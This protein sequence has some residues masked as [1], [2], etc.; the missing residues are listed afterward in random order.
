MARFE[1]GHTL[2]LAGHGFDERGPYLAINDM[3]SARQV[4]YGVRGATLSIRRL[5]K[6][7]CTGRFDLMTGD[8]S[9]CPLGVELLEGSKE[10]MCPACREATG[11]N[12]AFYYASS[13]SAQQRAYNATPHF[14]YLAFFAPGFVKA[15]ISSEV[16]GIN[17]LLDQG[18]RAARIVGRFDSAE[19]ARELE[20]A[21]CAQE[22]IF[23]TMR[24]SKKHELLA[25]V[26]FDFAQACV[27]LDVA[28]RRVCLADFG[29]VSS[30]GLADG[31]VRAQGA[32]SG[33]Q[34]SSLDDA[35]AAFAPGEGG[36][37]LDLNARYFVGGIPRCDTMVVLDEQV[38]EFAG[39]CCGAVGDA[40]VL[41]QEG[42]NYLAPVGEWVSHEIEVF[43]G[44]ICRAYDFEPVQ[45]SLF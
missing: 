24:A 20:A 43:E 6:R 18:A 38:P 42:M 35:L 44:E 37:Y 12:P 26:P 25:S 16:R 17:R 9:V 32:V 40:L 4:R 11:F 41:S 39:T 34:R 29:T 31:R 5:E 19:A 2:V 14:V 7:Y 27:E 45:V 1:P 8:V 30:E 33:V 15:G 23:E 10:N 21:L 13:L 28:A 36:I 3:T 22:G